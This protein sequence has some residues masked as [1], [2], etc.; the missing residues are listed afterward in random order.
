MTIVTLLLAGMLGVALRW[1]VGLMAAGTS[2]PVGTLVVNAL[3]GFLMGWLQGQPALSANMKLVLGVGFL[4]AFTTYS[5]YSW[6]TLKLWQ[7]GQ[8]WLAGINVILNNIFALGLC[9][10]GYSLASSN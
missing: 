8:W 2:F 3:G 5:A 4:G 1:G 9:G 6:D 10:L 7:A